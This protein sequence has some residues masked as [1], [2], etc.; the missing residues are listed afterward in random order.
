MWKDGNEQN[1]KLSLGRFQQSQSQYARKEMR[2]TGL[3]Q[4]ET[5]IQIM[6]KI[7][8][9]R[10]ITII[11]IIVILTRMMSII[12]LT[13]LLLNMPRCVIGLFEATR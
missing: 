4:K 12:V 10:V 8:I 9:I 2:L 5:M 3:A 1:F 13:F 6:N 11:T 7:I